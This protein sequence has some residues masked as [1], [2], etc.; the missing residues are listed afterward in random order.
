MEV[1]EMRRL[2][3]SLFLGLTL[4]G[5]A[6]STAF[7][8]APVKTTIWLDGAQVRTIVPPAAAP[9]EGTDKFFMVP[10]TGGVAAVGPGDKGYHGGHWAVNMVSWNVA[11]Y[12]LTSYDA[13][14]T[15]YRAGHIGITRVADADFKCPIQP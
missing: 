11:A 8:A 10:G 1:A 4:V 2:A 3:A 5:G 12:P 6:A 7:A 9:G 14:M 15:A 13:I